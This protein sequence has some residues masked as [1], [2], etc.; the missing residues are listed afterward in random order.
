[1]DVRPVLCPSAELLQAYRSG[2]LN[3]T[4]AVKVR[5]H[6]ESC[7]DCRRQAA[8]GPT[9][10]ASDWHVAT[11]APD[12]TLTREAKAPAPERAPDSLPP[13]LVGLRQFYD[14]VRE[15]NR[16]G[17]GVLYLADNRNLGGRTE[18]LKVVNQ[19]LLKE[20]PETV[21]RFRQ[22]IESVA[23]LNHPN[24]VT[25]YNTLRME[26]LL[27]L[28]MEYVP[29]RNLNEVVTTE[30]PLAVT[31]A[32]R[33][34]QQ[35]AE[36]LQHAFEKQTVHRDIKPSNLMLIREGRRPVVKILDFGLGKARSEKAVES[37]L[38]MGP[39]GTPDYIAPEQI[40]NARDA[41]I[42]ADLYSLGCTLYFLLAGK[43]PFSGG[44]LYD[45]LSA[46][47]AR[48]AKPL[49][50]VRADVP[51]A[52][53][54]VVSKLMAKEPAERYQH[55]D[56]VIEAL[57]PFVRPQS[58]ESLPPSVPDVALAS[59]PKSIGVWL[60]VAA[61]LMLTLG[62]GLWASGAF[63]GG[64]QGDAGQPAVQPIV[65][66]PAPDAKADAA[67]PVVDTTVTAS[68]AVKTPA[69]RE[70]KRPIEV[71]AIPESPKPKTGGTAVVV[72]SPPAEKPLPVS[73]PKPDP[74]KLVG[75]IEVGA[76]GVKAVVLEQADSPGTG[77][78]RLREEWRK[79]SNTSIA[80]VKDKKFRDDTLQATAEA[81]AGYYLKIH[82]EYRLDRVPLA[83]SSGVAGAV[84]G[85]AREI[86]R[87]K[88]CIA[89]TVARTVGAA[90]GKD[91]KARPFDKTAAQIEAET[92]VIT[93]EQEIEY[94]ILG[95]ESLR[96]WQWGVLNERIF[97]D[98]GSG[99]TKAGYY[100]QEEAGSSRATAFKALTGRVPG[101]EKFQQAVAKARKD[102]EGPGKARLTAVEIGTM[103][104]RLSKDLIAD[105]FEDAVGR[106]PRLVNAKEVY[107]SGGIVWSMATVLYPTKVRDREVPLGAAD[108]RAFRARVYA[109]YGTFPPVE[110][111]EGLPPEAKDELRRVRDTFAPDALAGGRTCWWRSPTLAIWRI[112]RSCST[113]IRILHGSSTWRGPNPGR[114]ARRSANPYFPWSPMWSLRD[115]KPL[116]R[117]RGADRARFAAVRLCRV[118]GRGACRGPG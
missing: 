69:P 79:S 67:P 74:S 56:E 68:P 21:E 100:E 9:D 109:S 61:G 116:P 102:Q 8:E 46:Q 86:Q 83:I 41:D 25:A 20:H 71:T 58:S 112:R 17:M 52:L 81:V 36:G 6:L 42:R 47:M 33:Y 111:E 28:A 4:A 31:E 91:K 66:P 97:I 51:P 73:K 60:T 39:I 35:V 62:F 108:L 32:C 5:A 45:I 113:A 72:P 98:V 65:A 118:I 11:P 24:I 96:H 85:D 55:P 18:V 22:E 110:G 106:K 2:M 101:T 37:G 70:E 88:Q 1:M 117:N 80:D 95:L 92:V 29:G 87:L 15:L 40:E 16:G 94:T 105:P 13:E 59:P 64:S 104:Q 49:N 115:A 63:T 93:G 53:A 84:E 26:D 75:A 99:T 50:Q 3:E 14:N 7:S 23:K 107:L 34:V 10:S 77:A 103:S 44:S 78:R 43:T 90:A 19:D 89:E 27:V 30:G 54:A 12:G 76:K 114:A 57:T 82:G 38:T 48:E